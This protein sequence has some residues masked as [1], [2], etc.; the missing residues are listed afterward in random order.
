MQC[1]ALLISNL[2]SFRVGSTLP[3][4]LLRD[5]DVPRSN[6][7]LGAEFGG[8]V[9][10][11]R[12]TPCPV[13]AVL[14]YRS[15]GDSGNPS[16]PMPSTRASRLCSTPGCISTHERPRR[17]PVRRGG[18]PCIHL[19]SAEPLL[20]VLAPGPLFAVE[21]TAAGRL[22]SGPVRR[23]RRTFQSHSCVR[24]VPAG[25]CDVTRAARSVS[26]RRSH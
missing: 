17:R 24:F 13:I 19:R 11:W 3:S 23:A 22:A 10:R 16:A 18:W 4:E 25:W 21:L 9:G 6:Q 8:V 1:L 7:K 15:N 26:R 14:T 2:N 20:A 12:G 5:S